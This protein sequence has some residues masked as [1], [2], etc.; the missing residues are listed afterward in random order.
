MKNKDLKHE[1]SDSRLEI[2]FCKPGSCCPSIIMDRNNDKIVIGG[3]DEGHTI[4]TKE[5]FKLFLEEAK[6]GTFDRYL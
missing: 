6:D 2:T 4:F 5:Q 1:I 3:N